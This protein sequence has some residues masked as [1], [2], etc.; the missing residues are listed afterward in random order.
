M[1]HSASESFPPD[2]ATSTRSPG[3]SIEKSWIA[4]VTW[5]RQNRSKCGTQKLAFARRTS[6]T[7]GSLHTR[8][9]TGSGSP[10]DDRANLDRVRVVEHC[11]ARHERV[12]AD[13][14]NR[15]TVHRQ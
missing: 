10:G 9:F 6:M 15:L 13:H 12:V 5:S 8:H 3:A 2:T 4:R 7:A 11:V 1:S 14:Q